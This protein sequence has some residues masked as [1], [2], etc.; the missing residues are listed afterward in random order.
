MGFLTL[1][2]TPVLHRPTAVGRITALAVD[3]GAQGLGVGRRLVEAAE[4]RCREAGLS[5]I[6]VTSGLS[7]TTPTTSIGIWATP[8]TALRFARSLGA[9][10]EPPQRDE[11][12]GIMGG[13]QRLR[14]CG[15]ARRPSDARTA[16]G[17]GVGEVAPR[18]ARQG[19]RRLA[20]HHAQDV[21]AAQRS[22]SSGARRCAVLWVDRRHAQGETETTCV[23]STR[24]GARAALVEEQPRE[25]QALIDTGRMQPAGVAEIERAKADGRWEAAYDPWSDRPSRRP[26]SS[27]RARC[28]AAG[29]R[30]F[31]ET[32][33]R[34][35]RFAIIFRSQTAEKPET[36]DAA[37]QSSS[38]CSSAARRFTTSSLR[39]SK[40][41]RL[42]AD[43]HGDGRHVD[44]AVTATG[45][46]S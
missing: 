3:P 36:R 37:S 28:V 12:C 15:S 1:H 34:H 27:R 41:R 6:E 24:R 9:V 33:D 39:G 2:Q 42:R 5:R 13:R 11:E 20:A 21:A 40:A 31:W 4:R 25:G 44:R 14:R 45:I 23:Q 16:G 19:Q 29:A 46:R 38:P 18:Q 7:H 30:A 10:R 35:N 26:R 43:N 22:P 32:L 17:S 8:I